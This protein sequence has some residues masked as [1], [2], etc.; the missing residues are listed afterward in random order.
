[1]LLHVG[2]KILWQIHCLFVLLI[3]T[4]QS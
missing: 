4:F 2:I 1:M 3:F